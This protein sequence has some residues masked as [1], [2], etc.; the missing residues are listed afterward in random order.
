MSRHLQAATHPL[1]WCLIDVRA[2]PEAQ[3]LPPELGAAA[4]AVPGD[5]VG[6]SSAMS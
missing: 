3:Q 2:D 5:W 6:G 4:V 1:P